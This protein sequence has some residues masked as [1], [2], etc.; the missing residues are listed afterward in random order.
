MGV[1]SVL[2]LLIFLSWSPYFEKGELDQGSVT[3][4]RNLDR[5][6]SQL[7]GLT[8]EGRRLWIF[9]P[10]MTLSQLVEPFSK[11]LHRVLIPQKDDEGHHAYRILSQSDVVYYIHRHRE[12]AVELLAKNLTELGI[13]P[14]SVV[15]ITAETSALEGFK[16]MTLE[17]VPAVAVLDANKKLVG[18]L[19]ASDLRGIT[20]RKLKKVLS[21]VMDFLRSIHGFVRDPIAITMNTTLDQAINHFVSAGVHRLWITNDNGEVIGVLSLTDVIKIFA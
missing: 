13:K 7:I 1:I 9:E 17:K 6:I 2:D 15:S 14:K 4:L 21:P 5:P 8:S 12:Q 10:T 11:G 19:S 3:S 20:T 18:N 16:T